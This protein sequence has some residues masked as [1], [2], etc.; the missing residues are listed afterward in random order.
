MMGNLR[1]SRGAREE[2]VN[3]GERWVCGENG[4]EEEEV[5]LSCFLKNSVEIARVSVH[6][7]TY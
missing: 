7:D 2:H 1:L 6:A 3:S 5:D 4:V